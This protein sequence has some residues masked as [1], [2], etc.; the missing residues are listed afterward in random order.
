MVPHES[1]ETLEIARQQTHVQSLQVGYRER[2]LELL[3]LVQGAC[4]T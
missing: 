2:V 1:K 4:E 3:C